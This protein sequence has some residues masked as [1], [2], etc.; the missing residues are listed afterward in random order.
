MKLDVKFTKVTGYEYA[1][2]IRYD[3]VAHRN[4]PT[5]GLGEVSG[6]CAIRN[7]EDNIAHQQMIVPKIASQ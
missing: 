1:C 5:Y 3:P 7:A 2:V 4:A 6:R